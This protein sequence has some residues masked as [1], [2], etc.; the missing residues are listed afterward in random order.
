MFRGMCIQRYLFSI[1]EETQTSKISIIFY[2]KF[3]FLP[4]VAQQT[5]QT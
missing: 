2:I 3:F 1:T 5:V 4:R